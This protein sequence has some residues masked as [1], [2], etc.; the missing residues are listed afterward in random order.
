MTPLLLRVWSI[1]AIAND[2]MVSR[3]QI[4]MTIA[5]P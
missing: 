4:G 5:Q 2:R 3:T 1:P